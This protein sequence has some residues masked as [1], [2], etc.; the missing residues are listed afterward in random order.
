M[1]NL[2]LIIIK[3]L[4]VSTEQN[5]NQEQALNSAVKIENRKTIR[6]FVIMLLFM[7]L[8]VFPIENNLL[9]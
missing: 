8:F 9:N 4:V 3:A 1:F 7:Q 5:R 2:H 6:M